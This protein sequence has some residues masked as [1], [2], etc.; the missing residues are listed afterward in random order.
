[1]TAP[2][3]GEPD[4]GA[5]LLIRRSERADVRS[6]R[7]LLALLDVER[8][9][10]AFIERA[11]PAGLDGRVVD[12]DVRSA[13]VGGGEAEPLLSV[14]PLHCSFGHC[15][16]LAEVVHRGPAIAQGLPDTISLAIDARCG[17]GAR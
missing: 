7:A 6:L 10:L 16:L 15:S 1:M 14:E 2:P 11:V 13:T 3:P 8:D 17:T 9:P 5:V 4:G 12:E